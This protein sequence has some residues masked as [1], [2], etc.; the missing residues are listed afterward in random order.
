VCPR[1]A[2][3]KD[4]LEL[5]RLKAVANLQKY[6]EEKN[7]ERSEGQAMGAR[8]RQPGSL[9][10]PP[11]ENTGKL[12]AKWARSYVV[13]EKSRPGSYCLSDPTGRVL[14]YS[15]NVENLCHVFV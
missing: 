6:Q 9:A 15:W 3:E 11:T 10:K 13:I 7:M 14:E 4:L 1:E 5:D 8:S 12:E 2:E